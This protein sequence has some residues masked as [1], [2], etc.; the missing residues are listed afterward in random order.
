MTASL[1]QLTTDH[2]AQTIGFIGLGNIGAP[3]ACNLQRAGYRIQA[4][5]LS[6]PALQRAC[7]AGLCTVATA[8]E[9]AQDADVLI[10]MLPT[11][12][13]VESLYL[14]CDGQAGLLESVASSSMQR[15]RSTP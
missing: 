9:A 5:D 14:G 1:D 3:M 7:E 11:S 10:T 8:A 12:R 4:F 15:S 13:H 2:N 6:A